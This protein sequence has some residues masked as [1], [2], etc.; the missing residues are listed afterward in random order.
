MVASG[1]SLKKVE[2]QRH[3]DTEAVQEGRVRLLPL[4]TL[5]LCGKLFFDAQ[6]GRLRCRILTPSS[7]APVRPGRRWR[8]AWRQAGMKVAIIE[9]KLVRRH[10]RQH[11]LHSDQDDGGQR[12]C[13][14]SGAP[15]RPSSA[16]SSPARSRSTWRG[17]RRARTRSPRSRATGVEQLAEEPERTARS[18]RAMP[19]SSRRTRCRSATT[20][21]ARRADLHQCRR[22]GVGARRCPG[23][24]RCPISPTAR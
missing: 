16:S 7:S 24:T 9:R 10:L 14:A 6:R 15:R 11:R 20:V 18:I 23:S 13:G 17:S 8:G 12:L 2:P 19:A 1:L 21:L 5:C 4:C 22:P 3:R